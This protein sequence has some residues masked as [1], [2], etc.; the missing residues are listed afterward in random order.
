MPGVGSGL[1]KFGS[2]LVAGV[3]MGVTGEL[4][5][6]PRGDVAGELAGSATLDVDGN[7]GN[8]ANAA[9]STEL[10]GAGGIAAGAG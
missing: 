4:A 3:G 8:G 2:G 6:E 9:A 10:V 7:G 5:I 1:A